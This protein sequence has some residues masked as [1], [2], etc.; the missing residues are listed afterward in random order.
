M[1]LSAAKSYIHDEIPKL[2]GSLDETSKNL[3]HLSLESRNL[4][5]QTS[6]D[7]LEKYKQDLHDMIDMHFD[8]LRLSFFS[9]CSTL[10]CKETSELFHENIEK[11][12]H[13]LKEFKDRLGGDVNENDIRAYKTRQFALK[14]KKMQEV[15]EEL[16]AP[17]QNVT[18]EEP[19]IIVNPRVYSRL[20]HTLC[21][22]LTVSLYHASPEI[23]EVEKDGRILI[24]APD[25]FITPDR[26]LPT[27]NEETKSLNLYSI[28]YD[29]STSIPL[30][31]PGEIPASSSII[32][33]PDSQII[34]CGGVNSNGT[35]T[36]KTYQFQTNKDTLSE[37]SNMLVKKAGHSLCYIS[38]A[39][40]G[41]LIFSIG[42][43]TNDSVR[44]K[45]CERYSV[46]E[47]KWEKIALLNAARSRAAV[48]PF[49]N[50]LIYAFY[51]TG[52]DMTNVLT[53]ER[54]DIA[55]NVWQRISIYNDFTGF[56]VSFA[57]AV[58]INAKQILV[59][60]GFYENEQERDCVSSSRKVLVFNT[61]NNTFRACHDALPLDFHLS[62][63]STPII[64]NREVYCLGFLFQT[65]KPNTSRL[66]DFDVVFRLGQENFD[67]RNV[68]CPANR[69]VV[70]NNAKEVIGNEKI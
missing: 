13:E 67:V 60:G 65:L 10:P 8:N 41:G 63:S 54:Y 38:D 25:Y 24:N 22:F 58:Q 51:G 66:L 34:L 37:L 42:G 27:L 14:C 26:V 55:L 57:G 39:E 61:N 48:T 49:D 68:L 16:A 64:D 45:I 15:Q 5:S 59:F 7:L 35:L 2:L 56:E 21:E 31:M 50:R 3:S 43:R 23:Q 30:N 36:N 11:I 40:R 19:E 17:K 33:T 69:K 52:S 44:T 20:Y 32:I 9:L 29:K 1:D 12:K 28:L 4:T 47:N 70:G 46:L 18:F 53:C 62:C 6:L